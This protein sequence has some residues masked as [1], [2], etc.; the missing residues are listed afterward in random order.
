MTGV[1]LCGET[2][3]TGRGVKTAAL[4][5]GIGAIIDPLTLNTRAFISTW[6]FWFIK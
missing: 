1:M 2:N 4:V 5:L 3:S 6:S